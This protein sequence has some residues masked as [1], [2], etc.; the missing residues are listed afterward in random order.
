MLASRKGS[1]QSKL[2]LD[3]ESFPSIHDARPSY[4]AIL[5]PIQ[6]GITDYTAQSF[7]SSPISTNSSSSLSKQSEEEVGPAAAYSEEHVFQ[8]AAILEHWQAI[9][10]SVG[11]EGRHLIDSRFTWSYKEEIELVRKLDFHVILLVWVMFFAM[12]LIRQNLG[13]ALASRSEHEHGNF[14]GDIGLTQNDINKGQFVYLLAFLLMEIPSG[15][16]SKWVGPENWVP[17][18]IFAWSMVGVGQSMIK[19]KTGFYIVRALL[20]MAQ[21]GFVPDMCLYL[22]YFYTSNEMNIRM[23]WF[24]T[25]LGASQIIGSLLSIA[26][27]NLNG[28]FEIEGWRYLFGTEACIS[29]L[30][31]FAAVALMPSTITKTTTWIIRKPWLSMHEQKILVNRLLRDDPTKG[32]MNSHQ[33]VTWEGIWDCLSDKSSLPIYALTIVSLIPYQ[34]PKMYLSF[35]LSSLGFNT[36]MSNLLAIPGTILFMI[37]TIWMTRLATHYGERS[38]ATAITNV[39]VF[40]CL[41]MLLTLPDTTKGHWGWVRYGVLSL[42]SAVPYPLS[43]L[44]GWVSQNSHSVQARTVSLCLVNISAQLAGIVSTFA[45]TDSDQPYYRHGNIR[46]AFLSCLSILFCVIVRYYYVAINQERAN[47]WQAL[48]EEQQVNYRINTKDYG[49]SR[50]DARLAY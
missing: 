24:Y 25:V 5:I 27:L 4:G 11:Y 47:Q 35:I 19:N 13:R 22:T 43:F 30:V 7:P 34:P 42:I 14:F 16:L 36:F 28:L 15:L 18:Q 29:L 37:N 41:A 9:Y 32:D 33:A 17:I 12:D 2:T 39:W 38:L 20:G 21:G 8:D 6:H 50:I 23:S 26:L 49:S 48:T 40:P 3:V 10:E 31:G 1:R 44:V 46:L 45:Y